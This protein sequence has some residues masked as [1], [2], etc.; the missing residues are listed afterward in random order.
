M[1]SSSSTLLDTS[2]KTLLRDLVILGGVRIGSITFTV[3][4]E[5]EL[6]ESLKVEILCLP[7]EKKNQ[8]P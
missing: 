1:S 4:R 5:Y 8:I 7:E 2:L 6:E 3:K